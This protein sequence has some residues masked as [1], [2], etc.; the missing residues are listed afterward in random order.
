M[1]HSGGIASLNGVTCEGVGSRRYFENKE[2]KLESKTVE[3]QNG[4]VVYE[5]HLPANYYR[6]KKLSL[7]GEGENLT[8]GS[9]SLLGTLGKTV[10]FGTE[11]ETSR[12]EQLIPEQYSLTVT[13][14]T[15]RYIVKGIFEKGQLVMLSLKD[16]HG[17]NHNYFIST[18][19]QSFTAM[20]V[21]TFQSSERQVDFKLNKEGLS[22]NY[23]VYL[24]VDDVT[25]D[26]NLE[27]QIS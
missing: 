11:A 12:T 18:A 19:A 20:C 8:L 3:I 23:Q 7:Y 26:L 17:Q 1:V 27:L 16:S 6:A 22:G 24:I 15:D 25:Y 13:E 14:E 21:G 2:V 5:L 10:E 9:G 4:K